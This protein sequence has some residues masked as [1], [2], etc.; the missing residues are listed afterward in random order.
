M[1]CRKCFWLALL[2]K[3]ADFSCCES[4]LASFIEAIDVHTCWPARH[5]LSHDATCNVS[6]NR[7]KREFCTCH[8]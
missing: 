6:A 8:S 3:A 5:S 7:C 4:G 2:S 1:L